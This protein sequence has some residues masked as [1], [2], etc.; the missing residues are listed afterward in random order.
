MNKI[1]IVLAIVAAGAIGWFLFQ[2]AEVDYVALVDND[3]VQL[4]NQLADLDKAVAFGT[5]TP[6]QAVEARTQIVSR[7]NTITTN[8]TAS[9]GTKLT[10]E[11]QSKLAAGLEKLKDTLVRYQATLLAVEETAE[12][13]LSEAEKRTLTVKGSTSNSVLTAVFLDTLSDM[14]SVVEDVVVDYETDETVD[15]VTETVIDTEEALTASSTVS[16]DTASTTDTGVVVD[17]D[18]E[19]VTDNADPETSTTE[20]EAEDVTEETT[21]NETTTDATVDEEAELQSGV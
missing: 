8:V 16:T 3:V 5:L 10:N 14:E 19:V 20:T 1:L 12:P 21:G 2:P 7:L 18:G 6:E 17:T 9:A 11:Q 13:A 4:E 15:E